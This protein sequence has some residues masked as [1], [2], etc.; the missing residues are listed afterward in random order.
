MD[1]LTLIFY[2]VRKMKKQKGVATVIAVG[3][4][5]IAFGVGIWFKS[6]SDVIDHPVEQMAEDI[7][8]DAG[9]DVDFSEDKKNQ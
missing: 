5:A 6:F 1:I 2:K 9:I 4:I 3:L 7:L 8:E